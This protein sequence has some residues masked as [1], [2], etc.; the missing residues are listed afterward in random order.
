MQTSPTQWL[1]IGEHV[2]R[3]KLELI[4]QKLRRQWFGRYDF[5][6]APSPT[7]QHFE[8]LVRHR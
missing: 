2:Q 4:V 5:Q 8:L 6:I 7:Q 3:E 1:K